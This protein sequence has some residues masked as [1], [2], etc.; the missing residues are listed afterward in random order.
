MKFISVSLRILAKFLKKVVVNFFL[1]K[2]CFNVVQLIICHLRKDDLLKNDS[3][4]LALYNLS[5]LKNSDFFF[6]GGLGIYNKD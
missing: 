1:R 6:L 5:I 3:Y 4:I 2:S